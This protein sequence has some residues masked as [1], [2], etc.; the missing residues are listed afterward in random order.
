MGRSDSNIFGDVSGRVGNLV[1][2]KLNG[3]T[4]VRIRPAGR[5]KKTTARQKENQ[6][7]FRHIMRYM[8][9]LNGIVNTGY[10]DVTEGRFTFHSALSANLIAYREAGK[11]EG[12]EWLKLSEGSRS[13]ADDV[14]LESLGAGR[15]RVSWNP[16][17]D[18]NS[19]NT[20]TAYVVALNNTTLRAYGVQSA[21]AFR[22]QG[23]VALE[24]RRASPGDEIYFFIFFQNV[25]GSFR[26]KSPANISCSQFIGMV[27]MPE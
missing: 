15:F 17:A 2:Y 6:T 20:D 3:K 8:Q 13:G 25:D 14:Q 4:V 27:V 5:K 21:T 9:C 10:Y 1:F 16:T 24:V 18:P 23:E 7:D 11:P 26:R 12:A 22:N 19:G